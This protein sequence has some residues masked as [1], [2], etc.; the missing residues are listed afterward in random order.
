MG[1][2]EVLE[3]FAAQTTSHGDVWNTVHESGRHHVH[4]LNTLQTTDSP[5]LYQ[6]FA[7]KQITLDQTYLTQKI[8]RIGS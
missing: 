2:M 8:A 5:K 4:A 7:A 6:T 1:Y 3:T